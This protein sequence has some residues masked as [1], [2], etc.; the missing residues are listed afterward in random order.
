MSSLIYQYN[1]QTPNKGALQSALAQSG[2]TILNVKKG[3]WRDDMGNDRGPMLEIEIED[4]G[5][6]LSILKD[7]LDATMQS[8]KGIRW[9][10]IPP[11]PP[12]TPIQKPRSKP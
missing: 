8:V 7:T 9:D 6:D 10:E 3:R 12:V 5:G 1:G 4:T 11:I 2:L